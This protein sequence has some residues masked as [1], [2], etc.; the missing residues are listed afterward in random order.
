MSATSRLARDMRR[1]RLDG[2]L[3]GEGALEL[4]VVRARLR[5]NVVGD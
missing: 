2:R 4:D 3:G 5:E 1:Q